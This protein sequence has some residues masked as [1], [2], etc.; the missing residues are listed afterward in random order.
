MLPLDAFC[1]E[2]MGH[3]WG[4][5]AEL[6]WYGSGPFRRVE[7]MSLGLLHD[8]PVRPGCVADIEVAGRLWKTFDAFG[9]HEATWLPY[10]ANAGFVHDPAGRREGLALQPAGQGLIGGHREHRRQALPAPR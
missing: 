2:F 4:V 10:W 9:R 1:A 6:L 3:N 8:V 7:A 5:P